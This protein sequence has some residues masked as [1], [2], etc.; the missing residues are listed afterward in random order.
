MTIRVLV[1]D[2]HPMVCDGLIAALA[3]QDDIEVARAC[4]SGEQAV[5][6][7]ANKLRVDV[8]VL[9]YSLPGMNG[10]ELAARISGPPY[11]VACLVLSSADT[12]DVVQRCVRAGAKGYLLKDVTG[13]RIAAS[14]RRVAAGELV[15]DSR[16][17][18][19]LFADTRP[20][21]S[22]GA[23]A[24]TAVERHVLELISAGMPN[25]EI[26]R[27]LHVSTGTVKNH[28]SRLLAKLG[29]SRRVEAVATAA[30][31]GLLERDPGVD[32]R[33]RVDP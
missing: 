10:A 29:V 5:E 1:V 11:G 14:I 6:A 17:G 18:Q 33:S 9:D 32:P 15:L 30:R 31:L 20:A 25:H 24:L 2:D 12:R 22:L 27:K 19:L 23:N 3:R 26:A 7:L 13:E 4:S 16:L 8:A 28:V 21:D